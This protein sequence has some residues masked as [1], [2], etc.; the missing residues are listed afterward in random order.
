MFFHLARTKDL[1]IEFSSMHWTLLLVTLAELHANADLFG[2][3][4]SESFKIKYKRYCSLL[5][6]ATKGIKNET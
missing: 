6:K 5:K 4:K 3:F 2:G 1:N